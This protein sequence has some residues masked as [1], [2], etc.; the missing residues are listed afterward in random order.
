MGNKHSQSEPKPSIIDQKEFQQKSEAYIQNSIKRYNDEIQNEYCHRLQTELERNLD[1]KIGEK[2]PF[3]LTIRRGWQVQC[4]YINKETDRKI[5]TR[6]MEEIL[7]KGHWKILKLEM[8]NDDS[9]SFDI[10]ITY[11]DSNLS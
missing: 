2:P 10:E 6:V 5:K 1:A 4:K 3:A 9:E 11:P 7:E 8:K